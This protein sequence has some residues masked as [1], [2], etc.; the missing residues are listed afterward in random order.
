VNDLLL[1]LA[2]Y[3]SSDTGHDLDGDGSVGI[4]DLL[5]F[6]DAYGECP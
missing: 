6:L 4:N 3:G 2:V 1:M 5:L